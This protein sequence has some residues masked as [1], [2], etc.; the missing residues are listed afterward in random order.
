ML[1]ADNE[2]TIGHKRRK[3]FTAMLSNYAMDKKNGVQWD[4][5]DVQ[6]LEGHRSY[7][8][9][10]ERESISALVEHLSKKFNMNIVAE[11]KNDLR[12]GVS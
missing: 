7:Y 3:Q 1:N 9:M 6:V 12:G 2:I 4:F 8:M 10:V 5:H 11:I